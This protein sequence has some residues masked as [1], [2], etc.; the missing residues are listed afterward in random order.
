MPEALDEACRKGTDPRRFPAAVGDQSDGGDD[1]RGAQR[2]RLPLSPANMISRSSRTIFSARWWKI[3]PPPMAALCA[4]ADA[5]RHELHEDHCS[6]P[7]DRLSRGARPLCRRRRQ[8][9]SRLQ[10]DGDACHCRDRHQMGQRWH[11]DGTGRLAAPCACEPARDRGGDAGRPAVPRPSAKPACLAAALRQSYGGRFRVAGTAA[12]RGD[13]ARQFVPHR[14]QGLARRP[15]ASRSG[16][17]T[18]GELRTGLGIV[19]SLAQGN[20]EA[21]AARDLM[22]MPCV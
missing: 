6:R 1:E 2:R 14:R 9:A 18:E 16:S 13:R 20:P 3:V 21:A 12:R 19:A 10:L 11:G 17:T 8:P 4:G 7:A 5:L 22:Q 15:C